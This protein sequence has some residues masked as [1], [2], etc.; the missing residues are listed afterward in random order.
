MSNIHKF[1]E[2]VKEDVAMVQATLSSSANTPIYF[3]MANYDL[4]VFIVFTGAQTSDASLT[5]QARQRIGAGGTE[6]NVGSASTVTTANSL[7]VIQVRGED[8]NVTGGYTH[9]GILITETGVH[10]FVVGAISLRMRARYKQA[11][12]LA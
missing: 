4:A 2:N 12:M 9:V 5:C 10:N 8:L 1:T 11:T 7:T 3:S 6:A